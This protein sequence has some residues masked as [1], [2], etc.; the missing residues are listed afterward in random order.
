MNFLFWSRRFRKSDMRFSTVR[1][2][3]P[4]APIH[5]TATMVVAVNQIRKTKMSTLVNSGTVKIAIRIMDWIT[6]TLSG[7]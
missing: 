1:I 5:L 6:K 2:S 7:S 4:T 3:V